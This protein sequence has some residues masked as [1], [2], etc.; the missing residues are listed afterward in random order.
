MRGSSPVD[1]C[2][3]DI[4]LVAWQQSIHHEIGCQGRHI[5]DTMV[6]V[7]KATGEQRHLNQVVIG[8]YVEEWTGEGGG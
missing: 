5:C 1:R 4:V 7:S 2:H 6:T 3:T 8:G